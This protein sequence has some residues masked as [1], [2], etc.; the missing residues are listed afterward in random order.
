MST[1][2]CLLQKN[3]THYS[4]KTIRSPLRPGSKTGFASE[5]SVSTRPKSATECRRRSLYSK[6]SEGSARISFPA[7]IA[8][9]IISCRWLFCRRETSRADAAK[10]PY[11]RQ[12]LR[13]TSAFSVY[14]KA[15]GAAAVPSEKSSRRF[16]RDDAHVIIS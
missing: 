4:I 13:A 16:A 5:T 7:E 8:R 14:G 10:T 11:A 6:I 15:Y 9:T 2:K 3:K 12:R 1:E